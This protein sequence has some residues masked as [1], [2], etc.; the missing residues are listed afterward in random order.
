MASEN[1]LLGNLACEALGRI[2]TPAALDALNEQAFGGH[3]E[4]RAHAAIA[5]ITADL[6]DSRNFRFFYL[7]YETDPF[8]RSKVESAIAAVSHGRT[9]SQ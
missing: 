9:E 7:G 4:R 8:S 5:L 3:P 1:P 2:G 6:T